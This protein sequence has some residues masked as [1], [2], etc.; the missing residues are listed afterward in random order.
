[1]GVIL[2][3]NHGVIG[4]L[5]FT[6]EA[7]KFS[8]RMGDALSKKNVTDKQLFQSSLAFNFSRSAIIDLKNELIKKWNVCY[9]KN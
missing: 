8:G 3:E 5:S 7:G 1:M 2:C 9:Y 4:D 6:I